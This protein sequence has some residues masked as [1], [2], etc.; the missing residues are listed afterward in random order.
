VTVDNYLKRQHP[1]IGFGELLVTFAPLT[2]HT[3][4]D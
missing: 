3:V 1:E 2:V 4:F